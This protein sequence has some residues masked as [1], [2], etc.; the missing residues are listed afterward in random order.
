MGYL[1][2]RRKLSYPLVRADLDVC[3]AP[4]E[5]NSRNHKPQAAKK[6]HKESAKM[7]RYELT[8]PLG[9]N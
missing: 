1:F 2:C 9:F 4:L 5:R 8:L 6:N 3:S 7:G